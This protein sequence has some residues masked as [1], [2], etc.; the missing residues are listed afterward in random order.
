MHPKQLD[1]VLVKVLG[2]SVC[3]HSISRVISEL[4]VFL[5]LADSVA[6]GHISVWQPLLHPLSSMV[7]FGLGV[8]LI[9]R[10][11]WVV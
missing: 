4:S 3:F 8:V 7:A 10:S 11:Q 9:V 6:R 5:Q 2:L 1:N